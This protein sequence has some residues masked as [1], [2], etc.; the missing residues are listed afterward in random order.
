M[1]QAFEELLKKSGET[2]YQVAKATGIATATLT[3]W[4]KGRYTPKIDK[5]LLIAE[6][7]GV[8]VETLIKREG[9]KNE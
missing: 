6:H 4:K 5:L 2:A 1:Y 8:P 3:D 7:F 9:G